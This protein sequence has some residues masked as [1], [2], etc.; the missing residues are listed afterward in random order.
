[1]GLTPRKVL[2][3]QMWTPPFP[4][5]KLQVI[6]IQNSP[7]NVSPREGHSHRWGQKRADGSPPLPLLRA[8]D[9]PVIVE[10]SQGN[11]AAEI[12]AHLLSRNHQLFL[13][14][15]AAAAAGLSGHQD[16]GPCVIE[17]GGPGDEG[18]V[19]VTEH[20]DA[21]LNGISCKEDVCVGGG[22]RT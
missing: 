11:G 4:L 5:Q 12:G 13:Q 9:L 10:V 7:E 14:L 16:D 2:Q 15:P 8:M 17:A 1:M 18:D 20:R 19:L 3:P 21:S 22:E 6:L